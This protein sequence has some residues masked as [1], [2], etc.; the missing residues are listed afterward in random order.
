[1]SDCVVP[2]AVL[3]PA[4]FLRR[5][6]HD[7]FRYWRQNHTTSATQFTNATTHSTYIT[8]TLCV[9]K[10]TQTV[11]IWAVAL[12]SWWE[13]SSTAAKSSTII[14][15]VISIPARNVA[16]MYVGGRGKSEGRYPLT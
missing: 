11:V 13:N 8:K 10:S 5:H 16:N 2:S 3:A 6:R 12:M 15:I 4:A 9:V 14:A 1:M 7:R